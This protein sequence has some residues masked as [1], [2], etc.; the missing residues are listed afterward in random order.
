MIFIEFKGFSCGILR[1]QAVLRG[2]EN[3]THLFSRA[4]EKRIFLFFLWGDLVQRPSPKTHPLEVAFSLLERVH[5]RSQT[6]RI[7][8]KK[9]AWGRV[10]WTGQKKEKGCAKKVGKNRQKIAYINSVQARCIVK[11]EAQISPLFWRISGG[12]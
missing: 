3:Q 2:S 5:L 4:T 6:E 7:W 1:E 9:I 10:G 12:F 8:V 11:G